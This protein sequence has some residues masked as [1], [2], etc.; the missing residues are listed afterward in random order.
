MQEGFSQEEIQNQEKTYSLEQFIR[1]LDY[2]LEK[3]GDKY[4]GLGIGQEPHIAGTV[5]MLCSSCKNLKEAFILGCKFFEVQGDF[6][7]ID[8]FDDRDHP[9]ISYTLA[10][11][12]QINSP[13]TARHE[14]DAMFAFLATIL[15]L[16]SN[17]VLV[18]YRINL[19]ISPP[20]DPK[21]YEQVLGVLPCFEEA[22]NEMIFK[23]RDLSIPMKA[24]N[25]E[26]FELLKS[27]V[28]NRLRQIKKQVR[29][30]EKVRTILLTS[31]RYSFPDMETVASRLNVSPR[32]LQRMLSNEN[33][34]FK[35]V[36]QDTRFD[37]AQKLLKQKD[38]S[39][40][41]ISYM[42]GYSDLGN[43]SRSYKRFTGSSP[44]EFRNSLTQ[45]QKM[46]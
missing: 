5:G 23:A 11:S 28:E 22:K 24:F 45:K 26:T 31:L 30:S 33:T 2:A 43:F 21:V 38:L 9:R 42:L 6:A 13:D 7:E 25:P 17:K 15:K 3:T 32:T 35:L 34:S 12:W 37:L 10:Q 4:Y 46:K 39:I 18:P 36:L 8:F 20:E 14:V 40:S 19:V 44:Q 16:N 27:H 1:V 29:V 41:E